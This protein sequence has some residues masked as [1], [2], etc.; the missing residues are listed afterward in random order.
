MNKQKILEELEDIG[1]AVSTAR[2]GGWIEKNTANAINAY[3]R[4]ALAALD[5]GVVPDW[6]A[7]A[8][9]KLGAERDNLPPNHVRIIQDFIGGLPPPPE[10]DDG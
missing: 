10:K 2:D 1:I 8:S 7:Y 5:D 4:E 6:Q 3:I 9:V